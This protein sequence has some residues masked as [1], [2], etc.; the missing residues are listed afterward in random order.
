MST[1]TTTTLRNYQQRAVEFAGIEGSK[2][3][4]LPTGSGKTLI[5]AFVINH[6]VKTKNKKVLFLVP[7]RLLVEQ[8]AEAI[9]YETNLSVQTYMSGSIT[10]DTIPDVLVATPAAFIALHRSRD[11]LRLENFG[12]LVFDEVHHVIKRHPYRNVARI[13]QNINNGVVAVPQIL[14]LSASLTYAMG[15]LAISNAVQELCAE[16]R[17]QGKCIFTVT[18]EV[19]QQNGYRKNVVTELQASGKANADDEDDFQGNCD[20]LQELELPGKVHE[21]LSV[22]LKHV[23][24]RLPPI[25]PLSLT[26]MEVISA[27]EVEVLARDP[28]FHSPIGRKNKKLADW[29]PFAHTKYESMKDQNLRNNYFLLSHLYEAVRII[30]NSRQ[31]NMELAFHYL[32]MS[33]VLVSPNSTIQGN[34]YRISEDDRIKVLQQQWNYYA[35]HFRNFQKLQI[36]L[37][38]K[39]T[40][41]QGDFRGIIFVKQRVSTHILKHF[42]DS[43]HI[44]SVNDDLWIVKRPDIN[45][46]TD[47]SMQLAH[48]Q[49]R[50]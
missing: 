3:V 47:L 9:R 24:Q 36:A 5:A 39:L 18:D 41:M 4:V 26:L 30:I 31:V 44:S 45:L 11:Y 16:L 49:Q 10:P 48:Q 46:V 29:G 6:T 1:T 15:T 12:L 2:I 19:L 32:I 13:F 23:N 27:I 22:F 7:T 33:N 14:G 21:G 43:W 20:S 28:T 38:E 8:Q 25:H 42:I 34:K 35:N 40:V 50:L 37:E 17:M